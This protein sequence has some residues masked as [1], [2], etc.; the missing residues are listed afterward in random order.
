M[1]IELIKNYEIY[2]IVN[3]FAL[4]IGISFGAVAQKTQFCFSGAIKD[5]L[6]FS[7]TKRAASVI[8]AMLV[9][10]IGT[11]LLTM[12]YDVDVSETVW[13]KE[14][15]N[16]FTIILGGCL[17]GSGMMIADGCSSRHLVKFAQ[18][19]NKSLVTLIFIAIF[20]YASLKGVFNSLVHALIS[21]EFLLTLSSSFENLQ[22]NIYFVVAILSIVLWILI[23]KPKRILVLSD[24]IVIGLL[25]TLGWYLTGVY[26]AET[27]E[28][29]TRYVPF[30]G[31]TF[32]GPSAKTLE[33]FM[34]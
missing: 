10:I 31:I 22:L 24:G 16:Y 20:A 1:M 29:D 21:N 15:I 19:D 14:D 13:L 34:H 17:F 33:F 25:I 23:K 2:E 28:F 9:A 8:T 3:V 5:Y 4:L 27:L 18:G 12:F 32:V 6:L 30:T 11:T 7:S 26:G